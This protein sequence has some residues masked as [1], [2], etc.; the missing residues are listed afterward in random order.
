MER[1]AIRDAAVRPSMPLREQSQI[2]R[3]VNAAKAKA[4]NRAH[5]PRQPGPRRDFANIKQPAD[6]KIATHEV[7]RSAAIG[8]S[9]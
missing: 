6:L 2:A 9:H 5:F 3:M 1:S 4:G 8:L 7:N